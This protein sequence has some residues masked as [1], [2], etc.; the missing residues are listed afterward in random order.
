M[1]TL[2]DFGADVPE[3]EPWKDADVLRELYHERGLDQSEIGDELGV[4]AGTIS[5][6][7]NKL[8]INTSHTKHGQSEAA[9]SSPCVECE[10]EVPGRGMMCAD[11]LDEARHKGRGHEYGN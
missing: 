6:W 1:S 8:S 5:Y 2:A 7:M 4:T 9:L 11:C 10:T 3:E